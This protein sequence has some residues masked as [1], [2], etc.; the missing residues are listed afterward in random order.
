MAVIGGK[1]ISKDGL[2][3]NDAGNVRSYYSGSSLWKDL[4]GNDVHFYQSGSGVDLTFETFSGIECFQ[5]NGAKAF[6]HDNGSDL[7]LSGAITLEFWVYF[8]GV[9]ERDTFFEKDGDTYLSYQQEIAMTLET[10]ND[11]SYFWSRPSYDYHQIAIPSSEVASFIVNNYN[12]TDPITPTAGQVRLGSGYVHAIEAG[13]YVSIARAY[14]REF[15]AEEIKE[16][17]NSERARFGI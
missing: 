8:G 7:D 2:I 4:S 14:D 12:A 1:N 10:D 15:S 16:N 13:N 9:G 5:F 3:L 11:M 17:F 6:A